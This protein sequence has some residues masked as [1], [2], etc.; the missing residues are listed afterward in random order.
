MLS[1]APNGEKVN[2]DCLGGNKPN[3]RLG[4]AFMKA[5]LVAV[6]THIPKRSDPYGSV[7]HPHRKSGERESTWLWSTP[8]FRD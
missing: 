3:A 5:T 7:F 2:P 4:A 1:A 6:N 8:S